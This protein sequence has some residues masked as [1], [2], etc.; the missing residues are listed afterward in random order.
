[1]NDRDQGRGA[2]LPAS[3]RFCPTVNTCAVDQPPC[4]LSLVRPP[5]SAATEPLSV[6]LKVATASLHA[7]IEDLLDLPTSIRDR[8][9]YGKWLSRFLGFYE[10]L[11]AALATVA[12]PDNCDPG[13]PALHSPRLIDDVRTLEIDPSGPP[14]APASL[15]PLLPTFA[16]VAGSRYVLMGATL[17]GRHILRGLDPSLRDELG[18]ATRF[19]EGGG[20]S[21]GCDWLACRKYLD[22]LGSRYP[23]LRRDVMSG[24]TGTFAAFQQ[25]FFPF[26]DERSRSR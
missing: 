10:P 4:E 26:C 5:P 6:L 25:W 24:A 22:E 16:H 3:P 17:G 18:T 12:H 14:R 15:L 13:T 1:M 7:Q 19:L 11:E 20:A 23:N 8:Q 21:A 9:D 2:A